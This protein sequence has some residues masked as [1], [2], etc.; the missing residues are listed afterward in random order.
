MT[1]RDRVAT[2][3]VAL[4]M[5]VG[6]WWL[7]MGW[8]GDLAIRGTI[9]VIA[10]KWPHVDGTP[11]VLV[12]AQLALTVIVAGLLGSRD[13][14]RQRAIFGLVLA[15]LLGPGLMATVA[16]VAD[17]EHDDGAQQKLQAEHQAIE[18]AR[19]QRQAEY[20]EMKRESDARHEA[21]IAAREEAIRAEREEALKNAD[22]RWREIEKRRRH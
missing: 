5:A 1:W 15:L 16:V 14:R 13:A 10:G 4:V 18:A 3:L 8:S 20:E 22:R 9:S 21:E 12:A 19:A 6:T 11:Y 7:L 17:A 2:S